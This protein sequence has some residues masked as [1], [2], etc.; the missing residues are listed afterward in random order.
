M[1]D[2]YKAIK[3]IVKYNKL[4]TAKALRAYLIITNQTGR[5]DTIIDRIIA[6]FD[7]LGLANIDLITSDFLKKYNIKNLFEVYE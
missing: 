3:L 2:I 5:I 1:R 4:P 7:E 6:D